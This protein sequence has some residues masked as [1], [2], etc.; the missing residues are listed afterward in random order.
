MRWYGEAVMPIPRRVGSKAEI[1]E[2]HDQPERYLRNYFE[3][4][5][6]HVSKGGRMYAIVLDLDTDILKQRHHNASYNNAYA[7]IRKFL[8]QRDFQWQQGTVY[9]GDPR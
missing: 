5:S 9:F 1:G 3:K 2:Q 6:P 4:E 8:E 7:D